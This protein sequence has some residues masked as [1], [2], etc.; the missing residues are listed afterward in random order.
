[1]H[2]KRISRPITAI[3]AAAVAFASQSFAGEMKL[4][5]GTFV[6]FGMVEQDVYVEDGNGMV[7]RVAAKDVDAAMNAKIFGAKESPPFQPMNLEPTATY[8]KGIDLGMTFSEWLSASA[9]GT[10]GCENG[11]A[12]VDISLSGLAPNAV[13]TMWN[14]IDAEPPTDPWQGIL[15]PLG[16]RDGSAATFNSDAD[17]NA[18]YQATF[19]PCL[20]VSGTQT[21]AGIA[22]AWH[23]DGKTHG[24]SPGALGVD[25]FAQLMSALIE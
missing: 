5:F 1:M 22:V 10:V 15:Y 24:A 17:G 18:R 19:E 3:T 14:F 12:K 9:T 7:H 8:E 11:Q 4:E 21:M 2:M 16:A 23:P 25:S 13:Y 6:D 20:Q